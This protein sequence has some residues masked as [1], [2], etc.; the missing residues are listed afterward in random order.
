MYP[1]V[2]LAWQ[3]CLHRNAASLRAG[4]THD[5]TH[6]CLPWDLDLWLELNNG[7]TL[8]IYDMGRLPM[9]KRS[10]L[11]AALKRRR[12]GLTIA[13]SSVRYR[14]RIR[15]FDKI[16]MQSRAICADRQFIY[17]EQS[18]WVRG[19]CAG[20][21]LYR[22]AVTNSGGIVSTDQVLAELGPDITLPQIPDWVEAW[23]VAEDLRPWPPMQT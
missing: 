14:K 22:T 8:S 1:F 4:E 19:T 9:A 7:L 5:S 15:V 23:I 3:F 21:A 13:G 20:H 17:L 16:K 10:G 6:Y 11:I 12:W 2:R 18:M